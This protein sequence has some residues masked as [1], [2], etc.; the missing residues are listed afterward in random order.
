MRSYVRGELNADEDFI[1]QPYDDSR[2]TRLGRF[3]RDS[4]LDEL[5]QLW[6]V[7]RGEM[8]LVGPR[9]HV[10]WEVDEYLDHHHRRHEV[11]PGITGLAQVRGRSN[12]PFER[13]VRYDLD[14]IDNR[15]IWLDLQI[16]FETLGQALGSNRDSDRRDETD[17]VVGAQVSSS[18]EN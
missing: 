11:R 17:G 7:L 4:G 16:V 8:S 3:L 15:S 2:T 6:N 10:P 13:A 1:F 12:I 5:P 18:R 9:P 14:Y